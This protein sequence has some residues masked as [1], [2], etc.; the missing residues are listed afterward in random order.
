[1]L[2][3]SKQIVCNYD[4]PYAVCA[5]SC[6][7]GSRVICASE[8]EGA[9]Y[10]FS[11]EN[12]SDIEQAWPGP[13]G[14]MTVCQVNE[15]EEFYITN[16][17][18]KGFN[19]KNSCISH[20]E[21]ENGK[22]ILEKCAVLPYL[23]RFSIIK[24]FG[25]KW[26]VGATLCDKKEFKDDWSCPGR[27]YVGK[28]EGTKLVQLREIYSDITKNHG[29]YTGPFG[30]YKEVVICT[31]S[32]GAF[33]VVP[34]QKETEDWFVKKILDVEIS[35]IRVCDIDGDG[36][37]ELI[38]IEG[39]HGSRMKIYKS[40]EGRYEEIYSYPI[41]FGHPIWCGELCGER[42]IIIGYKQSNSGLYILSPRKAE[43]FT[44]DVQMIDELEEFSN[45]DCTSHGDT[46]YVL[47]ACST[48]K[49]IKYTITE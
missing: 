27:I 10:S 16:Q 12:P 5:Y 46:F 1:M 20:V 48:G 15:R 31:G 34:P 2:K 3:I 8:V 23:H 7:R 21:R 19:A 33:V 26:I 6:E 25:D 43:R 45:I 36:T 39:F 4:Y 35:D 14:T 32:E 42:R 37:E 41:A 38:T 9:G 11:L 29:M 18:Y 13:G 24:V 22:W 47:A 30:G 49:V 28:L 44:M 40:N 17:F